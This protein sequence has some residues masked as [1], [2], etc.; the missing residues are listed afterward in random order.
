MSKAKKR[1]K[2]H[3]YFVAVRIRDALTSGGWNLAH[4]HQSATGTV[5]LAFTAPRSIRIRISDH[6][7]GFRQGPEREQA[8]LLLSGDKDADDPRVAGFIGD[9]LSWKPPI[10]T[11]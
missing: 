3:A 10:P 5:Y 6:G 2:D 8:T 11:R 9:M 1:T 7:G 4:Q